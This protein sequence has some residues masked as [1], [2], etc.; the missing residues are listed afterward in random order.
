GE[1]LAIADLF[2]VLVRF[3]QSTQDYDIVL[4]SH[5]G[6]Q[7]SNDKYS[8][9]VFADFGHKWESLR[10]VAHSAVQKFATNDRLVDMV[11]DCVDR[12]VKLMIDKEGIGQ[13]FVPLDYIYHLFLNILA[14]SAF[15]HSYDMEDKE[16]KQIKYVLRDF[17]R[18]AGNRFSLWEF[19]S[20]IRLWDRKLVRKQRQIIEDVKDL[21]R[22]KYHN[23]CNDYSDGIERDFCD[24]LISAKNEALREGKESVPYLTDDN[25]SMI[26][27]DLFFAGNDTTQR[28]F[29][30]IILLLTYYG[31]HVAFNSVL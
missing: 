23:H 9:V 20:L 16:Y 3:L 31:L 12:T 19:S 4:D 26:I 7:L 13:P 8:D 28:T 15:G 6:S 18:E 27:Y 10:R 25:L 5:N 11:T 30:W 22:H 29:Q 24:A 1:K 21:I 17:G 2:L 14:T